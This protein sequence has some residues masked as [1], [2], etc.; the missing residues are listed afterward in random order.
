MKR[1]A[2]MGRL[3]SS[4]LPPTALAFLV[5]LKLGVLLAFGPTMSPDSYGYIAYADAILDGSFRHV[6]LAGI[7]QPITLTRIIGFPAVIAAAKI[8]AGQHYAWVV[9]LF[10]FAASICATVMVYRLARAFQLGVWLSLFAAAAQATGMQYVVDQ[11]L[12]TDSLCG[13]TMTMATCLLAI[14]ALRRRPVG[15]TVFL[16][17]GLLI[18]AAFLI[19][20][21]IEYMV[22]G[23]APLVVAAVLVEPTRLRRWAAAGLVFLPLIATHFAYI[24]WN[25]ERVG[26][27]VVTTISQAALS[28][29]LVEAA[30]YDPTIFSGSTPFDDAGRRTVALVQSPPTDRIFGHDVEPSIILHRDYGW[31]AV[32]ISQVATQAYLRAWREHPIAMI[33]HFFYHISETQLH[34]AFRPSE[35]LRDI[36]LWNTGSEHEFGRMSAVREGKWW[37]VPAVVWHFLD[38]TISVVVF[39]AFLVITPI[40]LFR[41]GF[42]PETN[43]SIGC[44]C[45]YLLVGSLYAAVHLE[46]R[47]LTPVVAGSIV[48]GVVNI[49]W[50][51]AQRR[52]NQSQ[53]PA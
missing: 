34:Q 28:A 6:D 44:W 41:E 10:Q 38:D 50:L 46:P 37:M 23:F 31:D 26:A 11:T 42:T 2:A 5:V 15:L 48:V 47:Y 20:N 35:T 36:L 19:R 30:P 18:A 7:A 49:V 16:A 40:R 33:H 8:V 1:N 4:W 53:K 32:H 51:V 24:E 52:R 17:V 3:E 43:V 14:T 39:S 21:V 9:V 29:A 25:R 13:S 27:A 22:V 12:L 45:A